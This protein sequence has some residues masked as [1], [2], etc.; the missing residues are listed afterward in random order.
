[1]TQAETAA[2]VDPQ[3]FRNAMARFASGVTVVT[4]RDAHGVLSGFTASAFSSLSLDPPLVLVC[5]E[6]KSHSYDT[7]AACEQMAISVL[8]AGQGDEAWHFAKKDIDRFGGRELVQG[9][10]TGLPLVPGAL[11]HLECAVHERLPG[12]D[13]V[14]LVGRVLRAANTEAGP[15]I[16][17]NRTMGHFEA[18]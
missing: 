7:F 17:F 10:V 15:L 4:A 18:D 1:M 6:T 5:L 16:H 13:H 12:G 9:A 8:A 11:V 3:D 2:A 14:I